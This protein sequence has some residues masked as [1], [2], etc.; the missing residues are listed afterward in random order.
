MKP[1]LVIRN[2]LTAASHQI[3]NLA[4]V[5]CDADMSNLFKFSATF[6]YNSYAY[7]ARPIS[8]F[9]TNIVKKTF[10]SPNFRW[11]K[12]TTN[13]LID[14]YKLTL[15]FFKKSDEVRRNFFIIKIVFLFVKT[16][17]R[18]KW[19]LIFNNSPNYIIGC[20]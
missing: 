19:S 13:C 12:I 4:L 1:L 20:I 9:A 16:I 3:L 14:D 17:L 18:I 7:S 11:R 6:V 2:P 15:L 10:A 8:F 5:L